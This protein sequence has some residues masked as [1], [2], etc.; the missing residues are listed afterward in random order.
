[1]LILPHRAESFLALPYLFGLTFASLFFV[2]LLCSLFS[3]FLRDPG[4][5]QEHFRGISVS[6]LQLAAWIIQDQQAAP[7]STWICPTSAYPMDPTRADAFSI[8][9][10]SPSL[11][12]RE[13]AYLLFFSGGEGRR[14]STS[15]E[16]WERQDRM[17]SEMT[18]DQAKVCSHDRLHLEGAM[19]EARARIARDLANSGGP[20]SPA[21]A[22][23]VGQDSS[24]ESGDD[25][26]TPPTTPPA[27]INWSRLGR[28]ANDT[29]SASESL[30]LIVY[31]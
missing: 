5:R 20:S 3:F 27:R 14:V 26:H 25:L 9:L 19:E 15:F 13:H 22:L 16:P 24:D 28:T 30:P 12:T 21:T 1:M 8:A 10:F 7:A 4:F 29:S 2:Y 11:F 6:P 17:F 31:H 18:V 23:N